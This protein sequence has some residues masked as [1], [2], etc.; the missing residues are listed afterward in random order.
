VI[1][2]I[3]NDIEK[4]K[5]FSDALSR[6]PN[7]F[8]NLY[9]GMVEA[10]EAKKFISDIIVPTSASVSI[11]YSGGKECYRIRVSKNQRSRLPLEPDEIR[12]AVEKIF[13][14]SAEILFE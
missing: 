4:G 14:K 7:L 3:K 13:S 1:E 5:S 12:I 8:S 2:T 9:L 11:A 10:G 6:F